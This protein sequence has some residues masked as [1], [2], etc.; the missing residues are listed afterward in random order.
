MGH[1]Q[2]YLKRLWARV[3]MMFGLLGFAFLGYGRKSRRWQANGGQLPDEM[4]AYSLIAIGVLL[5][6]FQLYRD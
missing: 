6:A 2:N 5:F 4:V 1:I 3:P